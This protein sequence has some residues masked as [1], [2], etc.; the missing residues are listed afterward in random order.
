MISVW[1]MYALSCVWVVASLWCVWVLMRVERL[2]VLNERA[3]AA[4]RW[5]KANL[6]TSNRR[7]GGE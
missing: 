5:V 6:L 1:A 4:W 2:D 3:D 7:K